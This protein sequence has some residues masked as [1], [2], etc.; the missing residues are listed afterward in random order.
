MHKY[1]A[2]LILLIILSS[3]KTSYVQYA[4]QY[5]FK[6]LNGLPNYSNLNYWA[7]HPWKYDTSDSIPKSLRKSY[8]SDSTVD[9]FFLHPTSYSDKEKSL[10]WNAPIDDS[11]INA[12]TDY[13]SI[14]YQASVF[15]N[16]GRVF[17]P[18]YRQAN[19]FSYLPTSKEDTIKALAAFDTAYADVKMAF[20]YYLQHFNQGR[21]I[22]IAAHSQGTTHA[23]RLIKEFF[24][25][26]TLQN[27]LVVAYLV[28]MPVEKKY[29]NNIQPCEN[30]NQ[31]NCFC[32]W[33]TF[34]VNYLPDYIAQ[35]NNNVVVTNPLTWNTNQSVASIK[36]NKGSVLKNFNKIVPKVTNAQVHKGVIWAKHP[37]F[38]GSFLLRTKN[39]HI[40]D[41]NFYYISIRENVEKRIKMFWKK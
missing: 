31:T 11:L 4:K 24:D 37:R 29:F 35:E 36:E 22:I 30:E 10:G 21:P 16:A 17:A 28:G 40:A 3:C 23:K 13:S 26:K 38:F 27:K 2:I 1:F 41:Y 12:K 6:S 34:K 39:Y 18:R 9:V 14:L 32:T 7:A 20:E 25:G 5:N 8:I 19:Y 15:N 33:R